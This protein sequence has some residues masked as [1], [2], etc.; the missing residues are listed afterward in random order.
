MNLGATVA[1]V[2]PAGKTLFVGADRVLD[3]AIRLHLSTSLD[4]LVPALA[5]SIWRAPGDVLNP[6]WCVVP[7]ISLR[8]WVDQELARTEWA[9]SEGV[10]AN[11]RS[12]LPKDL[13]V[14]IERMALGEEWVDF[15]TETMALRILGAMHLERYEEARRLAEAIDEVVR[16][17]PHL[18]EP[19]HRADLPSGVAEA[20]AE[21]D[22]FEHGAHA[23]RHR[24]LE[25]LRSGVVDGLPTRLSVFGLPEVPGGP[26]LLELLGALSTQLEVDAFVPVPDLSLATAILDGSQRGP[27]RG[28]RR[29]AAEALELWATLNP[30]VVL[31]EEGVEEPS[32]DS[33]GR[34]QAALVGRSPVPGSSDTSV[35][36]V[37]AFGDE[38]Q[39]EQV[40]DA[41]FDAL[42]DGI[43]PHEV[44]VVSPDPASFSV[45]LERHWN[46]QPDEDDGGPRLPF[47]L[48]RARTQQQAN[49]LAASLSL[50]RLV[51]NYATLEHVADL[52]SMPAV[53][54]TL[55]L[56]LEAREQLL[57][58]A[59]EG[60]LIFGISAAQRA[61]FGV[62]EASSGPISPDIGTWE[63][64]TDA[65]AVATL[66]PPARDDEP[67]PLRPL[68]E[69]ADLGRFA[70]IQPLLR[71]LAAA[72]VL[73]AAPRLGRE[74]ETKVLGGWL[75]LLESWMAVIAAHT[76]SGDDSFERAVMRL[77]T[78]IDTV[79]GLDDLV[80]TFEQFLE[81]WDSLAATRS[82][83]RLHGRRG[84]VV[85]GLEDFS[86]AS[87]KVVCILGLDEDKLPEAT[88]RSPIMAAMAPTS[89][90]RRP[91]GDP[92][93][94]RRTQGALLAAVLSARKRL[95]VSWNVSSEET[96]TPVE[97][98]IVLSELLDAY[99]GVIGQPLETIL[100][101]QRSMVRRHGFFD[102][103][104][105]P[106]YDGRLRRIDD[107]R[108]SRVRELLPS[109]AEETSIDELV[110]FFRNPI[111]QHLRR[112]RNVLTP[113]SGEVAAVLPRIRV[114]DLTKYRL[115]ER[116]VN[117]ARNLP[118]VLAALEAIADGASYDR[119]FDVVGRATSALFAELAADPDLVGDVPPIFWSSQKLKSQL[120]LF[121]LNRYFDDLDHEV[122]DPLDAQAYRLIDLGDGGHVRLDVP[123][124]AATQDF[125][126]RRNLAT[127]MP[128]VLH[129]HP[130]EGS[131][132]RAVGRITEMLLEL[133]VLRINLP[134]EACRV[135]TFFLP[136][137]SD[138]YR[139]LQR[140]NTVPP[141][142]RHLN[143]SFELSATPATLPA[144]QARTQL[145]DLVK[146]WRRG[147]DEMPVLFRR[148]SAA[149]AFDGYGEAANVT[150]REE[151]ARYSFTERES[152]GEESELMSR[153][154]FPFSFRDLQRK[155]S[156]PSWA[157]D[158]GAA[159]QGVRWFFGDGG[160]RSAPHSLLDIHEGFR[161]HRDGPVARELE[162][163]L[164]EDDRSAIAKY[165]GI[166]APLLRSE[167]GEGNS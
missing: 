158:L 133:L 94:R 1:G 21:L 31:H 89:S 83:A 119:G 97:P 113:P 108:A 71:I 61:R 138:P 66:Y 145:T 164:Q 101:E 147:L 48:T 2:T 111:G 58:R 47:E 80:M 5:D 140:G 30:E 143:P 65:V 149:A 82:F 76:G 28:W 78:S 115:R 10:T 167:M 110:R 45:A 19:S 106:R 53:G 132:K 51:G 64:V 27:V 114:D 46:Y 32:A 154:L 26:R 22:L 54:A 161:A 81:L 159:G 85:A 39:V 43:A 79:A 134:D 56:D 118:A 75:D 126:V 117:E 37:G 11:V 42:A 23:Q 29:D 73:R 59:R 17:R 103:H 153:L 151:W 72:D 155:T 68:G 25:D 146:L 129:V 92:D 86:W 136:S 7:T 63:R 34:L 160:V 24:V 9:A 122:I 104:P 162:R 16:W 156:F 130:S 152:I 121:I 88:L 35:E 137:R 125:I 128:T 165:Q 33:L 163:A 105:R 36:L 50:L 55:G 87:Y 120:D 109:V 52:L 6:L 95:I 67:P 90:G 40:R 18:L 74:G 62:Y 102:D 127:K 166:G 157:A 3:R 69:P 38:R 139:K 70:S 107:E 15:G 124:S 14:E 20:M 112:A 4:S 41:I 13:A 93:V 96:G 141:G 8:S 12:I 98:P 57:S 135:V 84:V 99:G 148:T 49:R 100:Q 91:A 116:F 60:K 44:L 142:G 150:P 131:A 77:R 123:R 144:A